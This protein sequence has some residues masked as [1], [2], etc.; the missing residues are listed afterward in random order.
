MLALLVW[1]YLLAA[2]P[3]VRADAGWTEY[4]RVIELVPTTRHYYEVQLA[5]ESNQSGCRDD[6][7]FYLNY[8]QPGSDKMFDLFVEGLKNSLRL[9]VYVTGVCNLRGYSEISAV[10]ASPK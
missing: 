7:W 4:A 2:A 1:V 9:R 10:G 8:D 6:N 3:A 5:L